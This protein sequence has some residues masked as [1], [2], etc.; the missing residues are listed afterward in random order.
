MINI[1][2]IRK[3][4]NCNSTLEV[5]SLLEHVEKQLSNMILNKKIDYIKNGQVEL[6]ITLIV[7]PTDEEL[8]DS[9]KHTDKIFSVMSQAIDGD[10]FL[11]SVRNRLGHLVL[12]NSFSSL[13]IA[14]G[15]TE[16][17]SEKDNKS[18]NPK[19][20]EDA[21][22]F[23]AKDPKWTFDDI[24]LN[25]ETKERILRAL[26]II[27]NKELIFKKWGF[28]TVDKATKSILCFYGPAGTG[29]TMTAEAIGNYLQKPI[30]HSSY[31]EIESKWVGEGAK[32]LHAIF[33]F[34][35][36][37]DCVLFFDEADSFLSSRIE[38]TESSS[39]K[40]YNRMS[41]ELFQLLEEFNGC[42]IFSTNLLKDV[43][44][45]FKSRIIDSIR[46][47]LPDVNN[48]ILLI[49]RMLPK[50]FPLAKPLSEE[51][52][53]AIS[54]K[55]EG[56]SGRDIRKSLLLSLAGAAVKKKENGT[57]TFLYEDIIAGFDEVLAYKEK[58]L[59]ENGT[60]PNNVVENLVQKQKLNENIVDIAIYAM[61]SDGVVHEKEKELLNELSMALLSVP[62]T[63]PITTPERTIEDIC[64][65]TTDTLEKKTL[66]ETAIRVV[67]IDGVLDDKEVDFL[68]QLMTLMEVGED[69]NKKILEYCTEL[70]KLNNYWGAIEVK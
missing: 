26:S 36:D 57:L 13:L 41:N 1:K 30:V 16:Y 56:F 42:V 51:E 58:M 6:C 17:S 8:R 61:F 43:D 31:A 19:E 7:N 68:N 47:D 15:L 55:I 24:V 52:Y 35:E 21:P 10:A 5:N 12:P 20:D 60:I 50:Q 23:Y 29:K 32:N 3:I 65:N 45:A 4:N 44:D 66:L 67:C 14:I 59:A 28:S 46:F 54:E 69:I 34:A 70:T 53:H 63:E 2:Y 48:R 22:V 49:K 9:H 18:I 64:C 11:Y 38:N 62:L 37:N 40:H 33:K 25:H 39:D 27:E